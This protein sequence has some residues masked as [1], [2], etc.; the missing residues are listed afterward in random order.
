MSIE[1]KKMICIRCPLGCEMDVTVINDGQI[2]IGGNVCKMG[3][4]YAEDELFNPRRIVTTTV[5]VRNGRYA[6]APVWTTRPVP[7]DKVL[8]IMRVLSEI[9]IDAPVRVHQIIVSNILGLDADIEASGE[10]VSADTPTTSNPSAP[11][12]RKGALL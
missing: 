3:R 4:Q 5:R 8:D 10:I 1:Q 6:L 2:T 12:N 7:K 11:N 9:E